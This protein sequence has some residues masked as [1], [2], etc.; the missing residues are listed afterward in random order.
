MEIDSTRLLFDLKASIE[1]A[2][3]PN[4]VLV[5]LLIALAQIPHI[6]FNQQLT[7]EQLIPGCIRM[8]RRF[9]ALFLVLLDVRS[10]RRFCTLNRAEK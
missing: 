3:I 2:L 4:K 5:T 1:V 8:H 10:P 7:T 9:K 6:R